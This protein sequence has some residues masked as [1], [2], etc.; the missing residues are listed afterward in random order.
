MAARSQTKPENDTRKTHPLPEVFWKEDD[1]DAPADLPEP[2]A[3]V[4]VRRVT[5]RG[6]EDI[7]TLPIDQV[8]TRDHVREHFGSGTYKL[9]A[10]SVRGSILARTVLV[11]GL[12]Q[13]AAPAVHATPA[14]ASAPP[15]DPFVGTL[16]TAVTTLATQLAT[17]G[18]ESQ[19]TIL[20]AVTAL[21][22]TRITDQKELFHTLLNAKQQKGGG[23]LE[24]FMRGTEW[25]QE[26]L[27]KAG[28]GDAPAAPSS[29]AEFKE[30]L[31]AAKEFKAMQTIARPD[32]AA[33]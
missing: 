13:G 27:D 15:I 26:L 24:A 20:Q 4:Y 10:R 22:G 11:L 17:S 30:L 3:L 9:T 21:A 29:I 23:E 16:L 6:E 28:A 14:A 7:A 32:A 12:P 8:Q 19:S 33:E 5:A 1:D 25:I 18:K 2:I 31:Q